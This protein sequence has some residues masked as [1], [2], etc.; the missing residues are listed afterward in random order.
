MAPC[1]FHRA[2]NTAFEFDQPAIAFESENTLV[3]V[4]RAGMLQS[5]SE[6][7]EIDDLDRPTGKVAAERLGEIK[8]LEFSSLFRSVTHRRHCNLWSPGAMPGTSH[9]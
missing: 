4:E 6:H 5:R 1:R 9:T 8:A 7:A 3:D 2:H